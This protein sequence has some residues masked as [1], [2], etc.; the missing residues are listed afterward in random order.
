MDKIGTVLEDNMTSYLEHSKMRSF[1]PESPWHRAILRVRHL[2]NSQSLSV[3]RETTATCFPRVDFSKEIMCFSPNWKN[4]D[5]I[6]EVGVIYLSLNYLC[7]VMSFAILWFNNHHA[8]V[9][10]LQKLGSALSSLIGAIRPSASW[11]TF[12]KQLVKQRCCTDCT[13]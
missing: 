13:G 8:T 12:T 5:F 6:R 7:I 10:N 11:A 3:K 1:P 4:S 2:K 9:M